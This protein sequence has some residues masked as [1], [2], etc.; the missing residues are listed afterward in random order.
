[1]QMQ[2]K[3]KKKA[4]GFHY[5]VWKREVEARSIKRG[6]EGMQRHRFSVHLC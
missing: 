5:D 1:M 2:I 4:R 6:K 3:K